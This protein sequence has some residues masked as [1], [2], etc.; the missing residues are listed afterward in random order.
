MFCGCF[1]LCFYL[2]FIGK[3]LA[4]LMSWKHKYVVGFA[5]VGRGEFAYLVAGTAQELGMVSDKLYAI[6]VWALLVKALYI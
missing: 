4:G 5:M 2:Y 3:L 1:F 6:I